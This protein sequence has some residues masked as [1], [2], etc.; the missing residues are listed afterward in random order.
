MSMHT[1]RFFRYNLPM[2]SQPTNDHQLRA[3]HTEQPH[4]L[5]TLDTSLPGGGLS[6]WVGIKAGPALFPQVLAGATLPTA[7]LRYVV[8]AYLLAWASV[9]LGCSLVFRHLHVRSWQDTTFWLCVLMPA[10]LAL[11]AALLLTVAAW[12]PHWLRNTSLDS[13]MRYELHGVAL[14]STVLLARHLSYTAGQR[15]ARDED[16]L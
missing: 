14:G 3:V 2:R 15:L 6:F 9:V 7:F 1:L 10:G 12:A 4:Y 16:A 13:V 11:G 5:P 8:W